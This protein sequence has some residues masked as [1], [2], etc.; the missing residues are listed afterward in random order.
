MMEEKG[1]PLE[2]TSYRDMT[3]LVDSTSKVIS[4]RINSFWTSMKDGKGT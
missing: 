3:D 1:E 4:S 2:D